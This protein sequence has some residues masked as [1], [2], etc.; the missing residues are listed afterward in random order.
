MSEAL[1][2]CLHFV[3]GGRVLD[4][5]FE[6]NRERRRLVFVD[7]ARLLRRPNIETMKQWIEADHVYVS[8]ILAINDPENLD[9]ALRS[10]FLKLDFEPRLSEYPALMEKARAR[11]RMIATKENLSVS[12]VE[13]DSLVKQ[14]FP[15]LRA[16]T[17]E[18][19]RIFLRQNPTVSIAES[20]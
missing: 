11:C 9:Y 13:I 20:Q 8:F 4:E 1:K 7:E 2:W 15:D 19:F 14:T 10:R 6:E 3:L 18:L 12:E 17:I 16:M 5:F